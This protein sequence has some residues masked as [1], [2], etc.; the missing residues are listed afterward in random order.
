MALLIGAQSIAT[1][2]PITPSAFAQDGTSQP[3]NTE[4][5]ALLEEEY[6]NY[7][8]SGDDNVY[9]ESYELLETLSET[10]NCLKI[11]PQD[12]DALKDGEIDVRVTDYLLS[13]VM[14]APTGKGIC[15]IR[16]GRLTKNY[17]TDGIGKYDRETKTEIPEEDDRAISTH[18][19]GQAIDITE[20]GQVTC[21]LVERRHVGGSTTRW[22]KPRAI[23]VAWQSV[24]GIA[25]NPTP[26]SPSLMET[27][28]ALSAE[29]LL[30][31]LN[32]SGEMDAYV[33]Y[34]KGM[35]LQDI[36]SYVGANVILNNLG[37]TKITGDPLSDNLLN[38]IGF[39][40][41]EKNYG[42]LPDT[43]V[44]QDNSEPVTLAIA[45]ARLEESL[46]LPAGSLRGKGWEQVLESAGRRSLENALGLPT[47]YLEK[48]SLEEALRKET[49]KSALN[50]LELSDRAFDFVEGT[51]EKIEN[52]D[53]QG[54]VLAGI[55]MIADALKLT[56][57]QK[58]ELENAIKESRFPDLDPSTF[59]VNKDFPVSALALFFSS[60]PTEQVAAQKELE[61]LGQE[62]FKQM[63]GKNATT[64]QPTIQPGP[65]KPGRFIC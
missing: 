55:S 26:K 49:V 5:N 57:Q 42:D 40:V 61:R 28:T 48:H 46:N 6:A 2:L 24:D 20:V 54:V 8:Y 39:S 19:R 27:A 44:A 59:P 7:D 16:V 11:A 22:Q 56:D 43:L 62:F 21:K 30:R 23:K 47:L 35:T 14:P 31:M 38:T 34:V 32:D 18:H 36:T 50:H 63:I 53:E 13:L 17:D 10:D 65:K 52:N 25:R 33:Q 12:V 51:I 9:Y 60:N 15:P 4:I 58:D 41:L 37:V 3:V 64:P 29:G 1:T 45:R